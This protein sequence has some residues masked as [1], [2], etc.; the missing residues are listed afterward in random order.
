MSE[1]KVE[2]PEPEAPVATPATPAASEGDTEWKILLGE[3]KAQQAA[4]AS[5]LQE[6]KELA[7][8]LKSRLDDVEDRLSQNQSKMWEKAEALSQ[9]LT[10]LEVETQTPEPEVEAAV[11]EENVEESPEKTRKHPRL[12][13]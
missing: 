11:I 13:V 4:Q 3:L 8:S 10:E 9:R 6:L 2:I 12:I 5:L 7:E 1:I